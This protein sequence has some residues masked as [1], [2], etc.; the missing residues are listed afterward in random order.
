MTWH[1]MAPG[2]ATHSMGTYGYQTRK[3]ISGHTL[4]TAIGL[5]PTMVIPGCLITAGD[6]QPFTTAGGSL[7]ITMDGEWIPGHEWAPAWVSWRH[8]GGFFGWAPLLPG[9]NISI[10]FGG[11]NRIP[12][13]YWVCAPQ[14]YITRPNVYDYC[15]PALNVVNIIHNTTIINNTYINENH[16][17]VT[18]PRIDEIERVT[19]R[20]VNVY[21]INNDYAPGR[22]S[23]HNN[24]VNIFRPQINVSGNARPERVVDGNAYRMQHPEQ[25]IANRGFNGV[26]AFNHRNAA[27]LASTAKAAA[28][29]NRVVHFNPVNNRQ[30]GF[31]PGNQSSAQSMAPAQNQPVNRNNFPADNRNGQV[32]NRNERNQGQQAMQQPNQQVN[33]NNFPADNRNGQVNSRN[34]FNQDQQRQQQMQ[35]QNQQRQQQ[36]QA[37]QQQ[38]SSKGSSRCNNKINSVSS[39]HRP[40]NSK[41]SKGSKRCSS[42]IN[43]V[44][45]SRHRPGN[46]KTSKGSSRCNNK[47]NSV[48]SRH[49]LNNSRTSKGSSKCNS[50]ISSASKIRHRP[51]SSKTSKG[52]NSSW[53]NNSRPSNVKEDKR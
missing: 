49:R 6:G 29:D 4:H 23:I 8:G 37:R 22:A 50:K 27:T 44:N 38:D 16:T 48:S 17:Y 36:A 13:N 21:R 1:Q 24:V 14:E 45:S 25:A 41:T 42:K 35:Q 46:S 19:N 39:R 26:P 30:G 51:G 40:G 47:I 28:P 9:I 31:R 2:L 20:P 18:G 12:D 11:G 52:S 5:R 33:R 32:N 15:A 53:L 3:T 10:S 34:V 43:S 7:M